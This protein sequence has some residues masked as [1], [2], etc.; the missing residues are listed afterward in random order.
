M[1]KRIPFAVPVYCRLLKI[2][3]RITY[4]INL[5]KANY[6]HLKTIL[7][8]AETD[9]VRY[10]V[11]VF[12]SWHS[13]PL[14]RNLA[15]IDRLSFAGN[16]ILDAGCGVGHL[17]IAF[18]Q[19][20]D[21]VYAFDLS[22][23]RIKV[24][25]GVSKLMGIKNI[26]CS[27]HKIEELPYKDNFFDAIYCKEVIYFTDIQKVLDG[28][29]RVLKPRGKV[30]LTMVGLEW[31]FYHR[32]NSGDEPRKRMF[33]RYIYNT[34]WRRFIE[35]DILRGIKTHD[36]LHD[37]ITRDIPEYADKFN[38]DYDAY[39]NNTPMSIENDYVRAYSP[40]ETE[41][42]V[43]NAGFVDFQWA[44]EC[45]LILNSS[46]SQEPFHLEAQLH[47]YECVFFKPE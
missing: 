13:I 23:E 17:S 27:I 10:Q 8:F 3:R 29:Y 39:L 16:R 20:F 26:H 21:E 46:V 42:Y 44:P 47:V 5:C 28:F 19:R 36:E 11:N 45:Q 6:P 38:A 35:K 31:V 14:Y 34:Y 18:S 41:W 7:P 25:N 2:K 12:Y 33:E 30:Y 15:R 4:T 40:E 9:D 37:L 22:G 1:I 43:N 32:E 24:L